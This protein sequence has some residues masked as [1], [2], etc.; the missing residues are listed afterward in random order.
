[1]R[2]PMGDSIS[3]ATTR[4]HQGALYTLEP[5]FKD[6]HDVALMQRS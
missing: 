3:L 4:A 6:L 1:M 2:R 5:S